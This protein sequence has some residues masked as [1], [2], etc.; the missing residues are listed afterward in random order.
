MPVFGSVQ[1]PQAA[2]VGISMPQAV[3]DQA[4]KVYEQPIT[5]P[6]EVRKKEGKVG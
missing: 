5:C 1:K 6:I 3:M 2:N 4:I